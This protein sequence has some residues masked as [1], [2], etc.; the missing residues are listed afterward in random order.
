M[1]ERSSRCWGS[2]FFPQNGGNVYRALY[3]NRSPERG[4]HILQN[5][6]KYPLPLEARQGLPEP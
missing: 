3:Y 5:L 6:N 4:T 2:A 1:V